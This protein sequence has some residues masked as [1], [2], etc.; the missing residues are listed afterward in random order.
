M[1]LLLFGKFDKEKKS[2]FPVMG[3]VGMNTFCLQR[4]VERVC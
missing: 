3:G 2:M 4:L 1:S